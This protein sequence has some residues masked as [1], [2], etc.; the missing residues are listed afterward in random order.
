[1]LLTDNTAR[2]QTTLS[3]SKWSLRTT[4]HENEST[5]SE[6]LVESDMVRALAFGRFVMAWG[7]LAGFM[8]FGEAW[9]ADLASRVKSTALG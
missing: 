6:P 2:F 3:E 8:L 4:L 9:L 7:T 5:L 1:M